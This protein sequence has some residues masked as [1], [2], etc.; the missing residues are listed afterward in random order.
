M[1][2][3]KIVLTGTYESSHSKF[4]NHIKSGKN[5]KNALEIIKLFLKRLKK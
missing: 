4:R 3:N 2:E 5:N 1:E